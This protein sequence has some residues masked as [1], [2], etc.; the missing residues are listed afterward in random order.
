VYE[1]MDTDP[2]SDVD[3]KKV[4]YKSDI[5]EMSQRYVDE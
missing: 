1:I 2:G 3:P 4:K 5:S